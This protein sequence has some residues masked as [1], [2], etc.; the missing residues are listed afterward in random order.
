MIYWTLKTI[1]IQQ[2]FWFTEHIKC[3]PVLPWPY[4]IDCNLSVCPSL[5]ALELPRGGVD[6]QEA[7]LRELQEETGLVASSLHFLGQVAP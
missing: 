7:A 1:L 6:L 2:V 3:L 5:L 4:S